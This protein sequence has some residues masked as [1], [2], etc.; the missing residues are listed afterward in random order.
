MLPVASELPI[1]GP[2]GGDAPTSTAGEA[3]SRSIEAAD[4]ERFDATPAAAS[5]AVSNE[6]ESGSN[7]TEKETEH[8]E[9]GEH[10][11]AVSVAAADIPDQHVASDT[12]RPAVELGAT[13]AAGANRP[14]SP[15]S[16]VNQEGQADDLPTHGSWCDFF[17][18]LNLKGVIHSVASHFEL[19]KVAG[20][21]LHFKIAEQQT[22]LFNPRH[23]TS[24]ASAIGEYTGNPVEVVVAIAVTGEM[25]PHR[26][27]ELKERARVAAAEQALANDDSLT[28]LLADFDGE[29]V[30]GSVR[31]P[32]VDI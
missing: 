26:Q 11:E 21:V 10:T 18:E 7:A 14:S 9:L 22:A 13:V 31:P 23:A 12:L 20:R 15:S 28:S 1:S 27:R 32:L 25:T 2:N 19:D 17:E 24:L 6:L 5:M 16:H 30:A 4:S 8:V 29:V 3:A